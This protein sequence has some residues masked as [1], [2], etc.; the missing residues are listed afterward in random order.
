MDR[1]PSVSVVTPVY[2][3]AKF[4]VEAIESVLSQTRGDFEYVI[5]D[6]ASTDETNAIASH[7]A[8]RD[9]RI[10]LVRNERT[11]PVIEN[12]NA[13]VSL[14][15][16][17]VRFMKILHADDYLYPNCLEKMVD[18]AERHCSAKVIGCLR[19]RGNIVQCEGLPTDRQIFSGRD[20]ARLFL[21]REV[22]AFAPTSGMVH[23]DLVR[24]R[25]PFYPT[26]YLHADIATYL[27]ILDRSDFGMLH[28]VLCFSRTHDDSITTTVA[29]RRQT[30]MREWLMLLRDYGS[31]YFTEA[32][33]SEIERDHLR[34]YYRMIV[35]G[36]VTRPAEGFVGFHLD[37]L[38][39]MNRTPRAIDIARAIGDE[40]HASVCS[41][42]K[43]VE[44]LRNSLV[45]R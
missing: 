11:L 3:G 8:A 12:W 38:R 39:E 42:G 25:S 6:N 28:E 30:L 40:L 4:L 37:G 19:Q 23:A 44:H 35:R 34:R 41:P 45:R 32:E 43:V 7:F 17:D 36:A 24:E 15:S 27:D 29:E 5:L 14:I 18:L 26:R 21:R 10:R 22:F 20:V 16:D 31:R 2:N 9:P 1:R 13:A 33:I